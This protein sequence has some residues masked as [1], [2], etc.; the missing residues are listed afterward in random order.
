MHRRA[1]PFMVLL[2]LAGVSA[3]AC[4]K[5][6]G[7]SCSISTD[8]STTGDRQ[9][10]ISE[11]SGYCTQINCDPNGCPDN[12]LCIGFEAHAP[13]LERRYCMSGCTT[14]SDCRTPDYHCAHPDNRTCV[15][16]ANDTGLLPPGQTCNVLI[17]TVALSP[18]Y[19]APVAP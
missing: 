9:C 10:D 4:K 5:K 14:D 1:A 3:G 17:D 18:G 7:D 15:N 2:A 6:I 19:C 8:C 16:S 12:A 11:A 13:R